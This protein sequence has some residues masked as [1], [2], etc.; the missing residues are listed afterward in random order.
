[1]DE[2]ELIFFPP[3]YF[4]DV[5]LLLLMSSLFHPVFEVLFS[6]LSLTTTFNLSSCTYSVADRVMRATEPYINNSIKH[7]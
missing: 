1:M 2:I 7:P 5:N 4:H 6:S 3:K